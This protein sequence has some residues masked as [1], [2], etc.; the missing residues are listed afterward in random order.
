MPLSGSY[1]GEIL[2]HS[3]NFRLYMAHEA[4]QGAM[5]DIFRRFP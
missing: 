5:D 2:R 4:V 1:D 3:F